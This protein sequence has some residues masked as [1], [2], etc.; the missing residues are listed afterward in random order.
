MSTSTTKAVIYCRVSS[1][2]QMR[3]GDGLGSQETRCREFARMKG[4]EI[5]DVFRDEGASG[6]MIERP[7]MIAMLGFL[8]KHR[9]Q[10]SHAVLI[11]DISR[12]ARGLEA[13]IQLRTAITAAGGKL[14]SPSIEFGE[15]SVR[16]PTA[17]WSRIF[18]PPSPS[19][20]DRRTPSRPRTGCRRA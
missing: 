16:I 18:W 9:R 13:H 20:S 11:D 12:L 4:Y 17:C 8:K 5:A 1:A 2:A 6:S 14:E 10:T 19:T 15:D 7:G 3:K